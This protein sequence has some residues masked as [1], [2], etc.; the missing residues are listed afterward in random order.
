[1]TDGDAQRHALE[2]VG[3]QERFDVHLA[4][5]DAAENFD[6]RFGVE[7]GKPVEA[8]E[9]DEADDDAL[10]HNSRYSPT[11]VRTIRLVLARCPVPYHETSF[12][13]FGCGKGR[14]LLVASEFPFA[15]VVGVDYSSELCNTARRNIEN[16]TPSTRR[17][18][19]V[20]VFQSDATRFPIPDDAGVFY[21]YEPFVPEV[22][23]QVLSAVEKSLHDNPRPAAVCLV[24]AS[25][26]TT[27]DRRTESWRLAEVIESPDDPYFNSCIY[28]APG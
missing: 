19:D 15:R 2:G 25:L 20:R 5:L 23:E 3:Y 7:T 14:V 16:F 10:F 11:P 26:R 6:A 17:C 8:W 21:L 12:V 28:V 24:G 27:L 18:C 1:M 13:D 9:I 4:Q 22:A